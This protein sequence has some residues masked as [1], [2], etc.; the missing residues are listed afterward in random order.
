MIEALRIHALVRIAHASWS[1]SAAQL[2]M[3]MRRYAGR[4]WL[5]WERQ[6][7]GTMPVTLLGTGRR[8]RGDL[9]TKNNQSRYHENNY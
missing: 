7:H 3:C 8:P 5:F 4:L 6:R 9:T 2:S 1:L